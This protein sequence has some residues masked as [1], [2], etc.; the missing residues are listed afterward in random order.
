MN[1][2]PIGMPVTLP[3]LVALPITWLLI[4]DV[5]HLSDW[6]DDFIDA[7]NDANYPSNSCLIEP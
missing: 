1:R 5:A 6:R 7:A 3:R 2:L 4:R